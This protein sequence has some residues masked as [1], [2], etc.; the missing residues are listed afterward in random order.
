MALG[1]IATYA[2]VSKDPELIAYLDDQ[3]IAERSLHT[4]GRDSLDL[5]ALGEGANWSGWN[6]AFGGMW[7]AQR[8]LTSEVARAALKSPSIKAST[9]S[10]ARPFCPVETAQSYFDFIYAAGSAGLGAHHR[11]NQAL[12]EAAIARGVGTLHGFSEPPYYDVS[13]VNCPD[14]VC[15]C[16]SED[17]PG[18]DKE[19]AVHACTAPDGTEFNVL[20]CYGWKGT[21][22][23]DTPVPMAIRPASNYHWRPTLQHQRR[24]AWPDGWP[25]AP[26]SR[27]PNRL[28]AWPLGRW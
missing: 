11:A 23:A 18:S 10:R 9:R 13:M 6:M 14:S 21:L 19:V 22:I 24:R 26:G 4:I 3:L 7:T 8:Y 17:C 2:Y 1:F 27:F 12:D 16:Q 20:G 15:E 25:D 28:L 5:L